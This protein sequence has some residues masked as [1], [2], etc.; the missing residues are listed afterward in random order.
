MGDPVSYNENPDSPTV[1][2]RRLH[3]WRMAFFGLVILLAG[4][5]AGSAVTLLTVNR[6]GPPGPE[7]PPDFAAARMLE[8]IG[9][10]LR[11]SPQQMEQI[12]PILHRHMET[13]HAISEKGRTQISEQLRVMNQEISGVLDESQQRQWQRFLQD[14]PGPIRPGYGP[15]RPGSGPGRGPGT[16]GRFGPRRERLGPP[17]ALPDGP[18]TIPPE[19]P[20]PLEE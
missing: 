20:V 12:Q 7:G 10:R 14:L 2:L 18:S 15:R 8:R 9:P 3:R 16:E 17:Y 11:L 4:A 5:L 13:L 6:S 1:L 19:A